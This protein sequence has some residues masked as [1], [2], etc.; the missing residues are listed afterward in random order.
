MT[1]A[2]KSSQYPPCAY[3]SYETAAKNAISPKRVGHGG[4]RMAGVRGEH[5]EGQRG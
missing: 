5:G 1:G 3:A 2:T 4:L